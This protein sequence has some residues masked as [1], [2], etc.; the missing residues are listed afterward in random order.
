MKT[1][2]LNILQCTNLG[3]MER[4]AARMMSMLG[5]FQWQVLSLNK[6]GPGKSMFSD[7]GV[8]VFDLNYDKW[9][10]WRTVLPTH[11]FLHDAQPDLL[12]MTGHNLLATLGIPRS[13]DRPATLWLH[14]HH[15]G[16]KS[17]LAWRIIY[18]Q[19]VSVFNRIVFASEFIRTEAIRI[20]PRVARHSSVVYNPL[21]LETPVSANRKREAR[22]S[23]GVPTDAVV[24]GNAGW[25]IHR[26]RFDVFLRVV[27]KLIRWNPAVV[28]CIAGDG[29]LLPTLRQMT[30]EL[31]IHKQVHFVGSVTDMEPFYSSLDVLLFNSDWDAFPTTP[32]EAMAYGIP[33]VASCLNSGLSEIFDAEL[34]AQFYRGS[35]DI[36]E[37]TTLTRDA[38]GDSLL[39]LRQRSTIEDALDPVRQAQKFRRLI[40]GC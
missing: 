18:K 25:L 34:L 23:L 2:A 7:V 8:P 21:R 27:Q 11:S 38:V 24:I 37:L 12:L 14:Y 22:L 39:G 15:Q 9:T 26:K 6:A 3:G 28:A 20:A 31:A 13:Y 40:T 16:V 33:T 29:P 35:H 10:P 5:D 32:L 19:A 1:K 36:D 30:I 4:A 17:H